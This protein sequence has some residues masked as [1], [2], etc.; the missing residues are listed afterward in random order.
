MIQSL[1]ECHR[2]IV[3]YRELCP[4]RVLVSND[5]FQDRLLR[6]LP[7]EFELSA[8]D[9]FALIQVLEGCSIPP[10]IVDLAAD[11]TGGASIALWAS[12]SRVRLVL[13]PPGDD[14]R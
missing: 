12:Q 8:V 6:R 5:P 9:A 1:F 14:A 10:T 11:A 4:D 3:R 13:A 7:S 2:P